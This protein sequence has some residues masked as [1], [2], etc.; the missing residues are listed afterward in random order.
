M[1]LNSLFSFLLF[2][3]STTLFA[4][5]NTIVLDSANAAYAK[6]DYTKAIKLYDSV[7]AKGEIAPELY[8][9]LGNAFYKLNNIG[10]AILNYEK[11]K[12]LSPDDEDINVNLKLANQKTE[13]KIEAAPQLFL[14]TWKNVL[15]N[16]MSE[17]AWSEL[18]IFSIFLAL[19]LFAIYI[20]TSIRVWKQ[21]GFFGGSFLILFSISIFFVAKHKAELTLNSGTAIITAPTVTVSGSPNEKGTKLFI[22]HEGTKVTVTDEDG[23]WTEIKIVN[24]NVGW[25]PSHTISPI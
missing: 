17:K 1:K 5:E 23:S 9:N 21:I 2:L 6:G 12:K 14:T 7:I 13:D 11:A 10:F 3:F 19:I 4:S 25:V 22:L 20:F 15:V 16:I 24:G 18:C 8:F